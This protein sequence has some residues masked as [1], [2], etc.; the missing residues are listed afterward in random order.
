MKNLIK[1]NKS[2]MKTKF[3]PGKLCKLVSERPSFP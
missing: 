3:Y 2:L 1:F